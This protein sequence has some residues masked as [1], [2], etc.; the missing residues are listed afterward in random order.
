MVL[1]PQKRYAERRNGKRR[2][3]DN[4]PVRALAPQGCHAVDL[5]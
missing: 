2:S 1:S 3:P 5:P 4:A